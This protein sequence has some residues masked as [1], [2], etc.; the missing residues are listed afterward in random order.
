MGFLTISARDINQFLQMPETILIDLREHSEFT[1]GHIPSAKNVP[2]EEL[3]ENKFCL[4]KNYR[5]ILYCER[6]N[7]SLIVARKLAE[8][9]YNIINV[10]GGIH[11]YRGKLSV[12][13]VTKFFHK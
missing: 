5:L 3:E 10:Y 11:A 9:G 4:L 8:E 1:K 6:G 2:Y 13:W 7:T 12:D